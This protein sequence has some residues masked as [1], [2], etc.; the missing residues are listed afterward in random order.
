MEVEW[1]FPEDCDWFPSLLSGAPSQVFRGIW[2]PGFGGCG[3]ICV[4]IPGI[5]RFCTSTP[6]VSIGGEVGKG[7]PVSFG[8]WKADW[9]EKGYSRWMSSGLSWVVDWTISSISAFSNLSCRA[10]KLFIS[11]WAEHLVW[12]HPLP[13]GEMVPKSNIACLFYAWEYIFVYRF[14]E[15]RPHSI[16]LPPYLDF[17]I[18]LIIVNHVLAY[19][20]LHYRRQIPTDLIA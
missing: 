13:I 11:L 5:P 16:D 7:A 20:D 1:V 18:R 4:C 6:K 15:T 12:M 9:W 8:F 14:R 2:L 10:D 17:F 19:L 3:G